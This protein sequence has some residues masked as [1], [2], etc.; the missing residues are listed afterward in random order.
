MMVFRSALLA[1]A[2]AA[3]TTRA[4]AQA[5]VNA[6][7][8]TLGAAVERAIAANPAIAAARLQR[9]I[10][11][12]GVALARERPNPELAYEVSKETPRQSIGATIP[13]ELGGKRARRIDLAH[14]TVL[15]G[16]AELTR[17]M[18]E[19][20]TEVRR[21]YFDA[22]AA[23]ARVQIAEDV[24]ALAVRARDAARARAVAG[25]VPQSDVTQSE[26]ALANSDGDVIG[27]RG[28][29]AATTAELNAL[30][31]VPPGAP[32]RLTDVLSEGAVATLQDAMA[33]AT[34]SNVELQ[35]LD[36][37]IAEQAARIDLT[38]A[39]ATPDIAAG[40]TLTYDAEPEFRVGW[41]FAAALTVPIFTRPRAGVQ[42]EQDALTRLK[43]ERIAIAARIEGSIAAAVTRATAAKDQL[44]RY[45]SSVLPLALEA[46]RQ[47]QAA[48]DG[49]QVGLSALVQALQTAR[50]TRQR[51]LQA[52]L[53]YQHAI[54]DLERA[55]G[56]AIK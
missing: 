46:E 5:P 1:V 48:Y 28:E 25:D 35:L 4:L 44:M 17:L 8:L 42:I 3:A 32:V 34:Q 23:A 52:G 14:A 7:A 50:E 38:R 6:T 13:I 26:L 27:A 11:L 18:S 33:S 49:G 40:S 2:V 54:A 21:A 24:R 10:D 53:D 29:V 56:A 20:R 30:M 43:A 47:A 22:V 41:R 55:I 31:G 12:G 16:E 39:L 51:G 36:R 45:Q 37:R 19:T 15:V 9:P